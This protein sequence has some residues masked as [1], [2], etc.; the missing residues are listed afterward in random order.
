MKPSVRFVNFKYDTWDLSLT[1]MVCVPEDPEKVQSIV[2]IDPSQ[3]IAALRR[4]IGM[5]S[6]YRRFVPNFASINS[7]LTHLTK[8]N[9]PWNWTVECN[10]SF[11]KLKELLVTSPILSTPDFNRTIVLQTDASSYG[12]GAVL[13]QFFDDGECVICFLS[14]SLSRQERNY[15]TTERE[16]LAVIWSVEKLRH[17][18]E[19]AHFK[20]ITDHHSLL[21][22]NR[23]K[24][25][26]GRLARWALRLEPY[27]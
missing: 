25:P 12:I 5:A 20:V 18:L 6:W 27:D 17:Y 4:F 1:D 7:P 14:R 23:L 8:K 10:E 2:G 3:N 15:S 13:T 19:G 11:R 26:Q 21:W 24:D 22:L 9:T 16:C